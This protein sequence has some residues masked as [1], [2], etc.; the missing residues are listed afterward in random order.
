MF[1]GVLIIWFRL[2]LIG[3]SNGLVNIR[4]G[5]NGEKLGELCN[6]N[7]WISALR[8]SSDGRAIAIACS[9]GGEFNETNESSKEYKMP[10]IYVRFTHNPQ[11]L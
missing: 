8:F 9:Y 3:D 2:F 10:Q 4:N 1:N 11:E 7:H 6:Y 5:S